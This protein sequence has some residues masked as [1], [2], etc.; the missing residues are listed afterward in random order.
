MMQR[1]KII[2]VGGG[3][4]GLFAAKA[5][6]K[7]GLEVE[8][9]E[10][11]PELGEVGAGVYITPNSVRQLQR[12]GLGAEVEKYGA[13]V[14][15]ES[16]YFRADGTPIAPV[17]V[18]DSSGWSANF[19]MHRADFV[20]FLVASLPKGVVHTGHRCVGFEQAGDKARVTFAN[21]ASAEADI[22]V[23]ADGIHSELRPHVFP[24]SQPVFSG[25]VAYRGTVP[26]ERLPD[27]PNERW[28]MWLGK[29]KHFLVF[30]LR[31]GKLLNYVGFVPAD[32]K[33]KES[34]S[35]PGDPDML[36]ADFAGWAPPITQLL[37]KVEKTFRWALYDR[38]PMPTWTKGR[39]TLLGD[40]AHPMLPHLGQGANQAIE[41]GMALAT[42]LSRV[43][44]A[45]APQ[46]LIAYERLR[47]ER[48]A[49]VQ[50]GARQNGMRYDSAYADIAQRDAELKA[51]V[52]FRKALYDFD[53]VP[54]AEKVAADLA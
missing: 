27:F 42:I 29:G 22:V 16:Q 47:R 19:G 4:G 41:D 20:D 45:P 49:E 34:W 51:H 17:Q 15:P 38:E 25:T 32:K 21:G 23:G 18:T 7:R 9:Y 8:L 3:I 35:A 28:L 39:L 36:R 46:A 11:A 50:R 54:E 1:P 40:A 30:P 26:H 13:R 31:A 33:M 6:L 48:V 5:L 14:G 2:I 10:Q 53:V 37:S 12:V 24:P 52:E 44:N 43:D